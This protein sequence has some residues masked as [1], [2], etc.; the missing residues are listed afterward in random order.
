[1][2]G[3]PYWEREGELPM[4]RQVHPLTAGDSVSGEHVEKGDIGLIGA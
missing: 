4:D 1:M 3:S 2:V